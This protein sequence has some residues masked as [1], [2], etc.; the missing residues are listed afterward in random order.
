[1]EVILHRTEYVDNT[2][3]QKFEY[4]RR[5]PGHTQPNH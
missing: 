1:M 4:W 5:R 3:L 2:I